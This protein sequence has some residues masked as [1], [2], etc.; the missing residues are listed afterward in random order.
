MKK[1]RV[2]QYVLIVIGAFMVLCGSLWSVGV[3]ISSAFLGY[4]VSE[5][6]G[7]EGE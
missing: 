7:G 6:G 3:A 4:W 5:E 2:A 1:H